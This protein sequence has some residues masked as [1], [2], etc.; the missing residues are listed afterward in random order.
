MPILFQMYVEKYATSLLSEF[1]FEYAAISSSNLKKYSCKATKAIDSI[2]SHA[3]EGSVIFVVGGEVLCCRSRSL[4]LH[5]QSNAFQ[6]FLFKAFN[7]LVPKAFQWYSS[8]C[9]STS[10]EFPFIP[11]SH[12][13]SHKV[14]V[15][16]NTVG[17]DFSTLTESELSEVKSRLC[18]AEYISVRDK[19]T[20]NNMS[21]IEVNSIL[22]PDS[23]FIMSDLI[24]Y[25]CL[26]SKVKQSIVTQLN[27]KYYVFQAAP[28]KVGNSINECIS[29]IR[30]LAQQGRV[31]VVLLPIGYASGHD[32][33]MLL[34]K[35]HQAIP[36]VTLMLNNLTIWEIM[37]VIAKS[38]AY[39]GTSLHGAI[40]AMS[41]GIPHF[42]INK[43]VVKLD[44]FLRDWSVAPFNRCYSI[45][46]ISQL[47]E[48]I[49]KENTL[50]LKKQSKLNIAKVK[51][52]YEAML[53]S[54]VS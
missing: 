25:D 15:V 22:A 37:Y 36:D 24:S 31:K 8:R 13:F 28:N 30:I 33:Y 40:T 53:A 6:H 21:S 5:M 46:E 45:S 41:F 16:F 19:R 50:E 43:K 10:W 12:F 54:I 51:A 44:A 4:F 3:P 18:A 32:D 49:S 39:F 1:E 17:G 14:K 27:G 35:I 42:G 34:D 9:Y 23:A 7:K 48:Y 52:N 29:Q 2:V 11:S 38:S 47:V 20:F 26:V